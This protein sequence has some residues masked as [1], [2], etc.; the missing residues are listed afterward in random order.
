[1]AQVS[2]CGWL[3]SVLRA[4]LGT[5]A[6]IPSHNS[7]S[8]NIG[9]TGADGITKRNGNAHTLATSCQI[10]SF[11]GLNDNLGELLLI[12]YQ[13][14]VED[15]INHL[16]IKQFAAKVRATD[17]I[18]KLLKSWIKV[19]YPEEI[20]IGMLGRLQE[21]EFDDK[22]RNRLLGGNVD[23][24]GDMSNSENNRVCSHLLN[25]LEKNCLS[26]NGNNDN[27]SNE[28]DNDNNYNDSDGD[29]NR[30]NRDYRH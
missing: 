3:L 25:L 22:K 6:Y 19:Y 30:N 8:N 23:S 2:A 17:Q 13:S 26:F 21:E 15:V 9:V 14:S 24:R 4:P 29:N 5:G 28:N 7:N 10:L 12:A 20:P 1:M 16:G 27:N 11:N 18:K